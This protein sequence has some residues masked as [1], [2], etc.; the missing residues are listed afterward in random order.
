MNG[1]KEFF[2]CKKSKCVWDPWTIQNFSW[3]KDWDDYNKSNKNILVYF[4]K[5]IFLLVGLMVC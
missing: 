1:D 5:D 4:I 2:T 3:L